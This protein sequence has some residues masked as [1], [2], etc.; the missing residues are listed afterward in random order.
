[1]SSIV[2]T[3]KLRRFF[4]E[5]F[6]FK[7]NLGFD[8][9]RKE[10]KDQIRLDWD[11]KQ[12]KSGASIYKISFYY[13]LNEANPEK[14]AYRYKIKVKATGFFEVPTGLNEETLAIILNHDAIVIIIGYLRGVIA[15][16]TA[17]CILGRY[18]I[19]LLDMKKILAER[20]KKE[21]KPKGREAKPK[22]KN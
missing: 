7:T 14:D 13:D 11:I 20:Y 1:M 18:E 19:P 8:I 15:T 9:K 3:L 12:D 17:N 21:E 10:D 5:N 22:K 2:S 4:I 6:E 16:F